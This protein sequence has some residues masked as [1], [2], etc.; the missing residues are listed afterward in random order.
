MLGVSSMMILL[1]LEL[2]G[3][4]DDPAPGLRV[5]LQIPSAEPMEVDP[6]LRTE[7]ALQQLLF[8]HL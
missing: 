7:Q 2:A 1:F 4:V 5:R 6:S 8:G 3:R